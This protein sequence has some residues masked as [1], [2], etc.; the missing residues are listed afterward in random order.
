M[1][2][3]MHLGIPIERLTKHLVS[4]DQALRRVAAALIAQVLCFLDEVPPE[5]GLAAHDE[6]SVVSD[7]VREALRAAD[8]ELPAAPVEPP[9]GSIIRGGPWP[10]PRDRW[11]QIRSVDAR[12][13]V[14]LETFQEL[15]QLAVRGEP[16]LR[17]PSL[18]SLKDL[19]W[20][21]SHWTPDLVPLLPG[22]A[23]DLAAT[24]A[25]ADEITR[26]LT[27]DVLRNLGPQ[28]AVAVDTLLAMLAREVPGLDSLLLST[29]GSIGSAA[30]GAAPLVL[31]RLVKLEQ[32]E[33]VDEERQSFLHLTLQ[34][35]EASS[36][37]TLEWLEQR[38]R[39]SSGESRR[40]AVESLGL[41]GRSDAGLASLFL[42]LVRQDEPKLRDAAIVALGNLGVSTPEVVEILGRLL[43]APPGRR[44]PRPRPGKP[45]SSDREAA[46]QDAA[47]I[48]KEMS[49]RAADPLKDS[50]AEAAGALGK[51]R[52]RAPEIV[53]A[54]T[55]AARDPDDHLR[56]E[57]TRALGDIGVA[58]PGV[59]GAL[60][61][62]LDDSEICATAAHA[63]GR[64]GPA[65]RDALEALR[66]IAV[67]A[68]PGD[69][70]LLGPVNEAIEAISA[71]PALRLAGHDEHD[72][73]KV[74]KSRG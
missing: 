43:T 62:N 55:S 70:W 52:C 23:A 45:P 37:S 66:R 67:H 40:L 64:L 18:L 14:T 59:I 38:A 2:D 33:P 26:A 1:S 42:D 54:L 46:V 73:G 72:E 57:A 36:P 47:M 4:D 71:R 30:S 22:L 15:C 56:L 61:A 25:G 6:D 3:A 50:R 27:L 34:K 74:P 17:W 35:I 5:V 29:L 19:A 49:E 51:L 11:R 69:C 65:A 60:I 39:L 21:S 32:Q 28:A 9:G 63:L 24:L 31:D 20:F 13:G 53:S 7:L 68:D 12:K 16:G 10:S 41:L 58:D 8:R 48:L 44:L